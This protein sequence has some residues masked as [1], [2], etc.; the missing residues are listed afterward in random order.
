MPCG[1]SLTS[2]AVHFIK[3]LRV[4]NF[5]HLLKVGVTVGLRLSL[6]G[7][8]DSISS[9]DSVTSSRR[10]EETARVGVTAATGVKQLPTADEAEL[11][12][13]SPLVA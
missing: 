1:L 11:P 12:F 10:P 2:A 4:V 8:A 5:F 3:E 7:P 9:S 13:W 6:R